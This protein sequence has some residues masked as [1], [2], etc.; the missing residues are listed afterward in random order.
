MEDENKALVIGSG[1]AG[2][3]TAAR[4]QAQ[5]WQVTVFEAN[6]HAGGKV[7][8]VGGK[9]Y[10]FDAGPSLFT[11]PHLLEEVVRDCG[12]EPRDYFEYYRKE[13][14]CQYFWDDGTELTA[15]GEPERFAREAEEKL[16]VPAQR[17]RAHL[18]TARRIYQRTSPVFLEKSLHRWQS[19]LNRETLQALGQMHRLHLQD[20]L[21]RVNE[22]ALQHPKLVQLFDR[23]ATYN[24]SSPYLTPGVMSSIPHLE[25]NVGTYYP[26]GGMHSITRTLY[27]LAVDLGVKFHFGTPV[28]SI[29]IRHQRAVGVRVA[30][31][32]IPA[33]RVISNMD[34]VHT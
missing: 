15:Y 34:I 6:Q 1:I 8:V 28:E 11:L 13:V 2:L 23:F 33:A 14:A 7:S 16:G 25:H 26:R 5:G 31:V 4:L 19:Y 29:V 24:G 21:H 17:V 18:Q 22:R 32:E 10:R 30:G 20:S 9:G 27:Q 3:A 12:K